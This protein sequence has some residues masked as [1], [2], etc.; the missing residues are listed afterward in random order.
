MLANIP[1]MVLSAF[2][3][4]GKARRD[5]MAK[6]LRELWLTNNQLVT[7]NPELRQLKALTV[8]CLSG[9][10]LTKI[11]VFL[12][13]LKGLK[14]LML[15]KNEI[16][17]VPDQ[18]QDLR[19]VCVRLRACVHGWAGGSPNCTPLAHVH[20]HPHQPVGY[21]RRMLAACLTSRTH[22]RN[23]TRLHTRTHVRSF[24]LLADTLKNFTWTTTSWTRLAWC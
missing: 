18:L 12:S 16:Q 6:G 24:P 17:S 10:R 8:L 15:S 7:V 11:P 23:Y 5:A 9:N 1:G 3:I 20:L 4:A 21:C 14:R 2:R 19:H 22:T 13:S